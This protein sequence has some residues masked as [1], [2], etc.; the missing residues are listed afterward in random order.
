M[1]KLLLSTC[2]CALISGCSTTSYF[3]DEGNRQQL[4]SNSSN[5]MLYSSARPNHS[6]QVWT[7]TNNQHRSINKN[8]NSYARGLMQ[9]LLTNLQY[10]GARTP[11]A[12]AD[13]VYLGSDFNSSNLVGKQLAEALSHEVH[14]LGVPVVD[15]KLTGYI[16]V[17]PDGSF[18]LSKDYLELSGE[19]PLRYILTGTLVEG[20]EGTIVNARIVGVE[21]KA[22][23]ASAQSVIPRDVTEAL[24]IVL[25]NDGLV[26]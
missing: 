12:V 20:R 22:I 8:I 16:R 7:A 17:T 4:S 13:F 23:V 3:S 1:K 19:L 6:S 9:D 15:Y 24:N 5:V 10:V 2:V 11:L 18:A 26:N 14:K 25:S 21:S